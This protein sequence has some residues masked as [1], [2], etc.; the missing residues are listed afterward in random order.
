M[1]QL[2][3]WN[4]R[5]AVACVV[6]TVGLLITYRSNL[7]FQVPLWYSRPWGEEQLA[8]PYWLWLV[9]ALILAIALADYLGG[10]WLKKEELLADIWMIGG[11]ITQ[12]ILTLAIVRIIWIVVF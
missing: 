1:K 9:P 7:P 11:M 4:V 5:L 6:V 8:S 3:L 12:F 2:A 10:Q